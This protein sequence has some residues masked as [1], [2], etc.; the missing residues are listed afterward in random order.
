MSFHP[1]PYAMRAGRTWADNCEELLAH[2]GIVGLLLIFILLMFVI[3]EIPLTIVILGFL[4]LCVACLRTYQLAEGEPSTPP[5]MF[6]P[7]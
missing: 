5:P 4:S 6:P 1:G 2:L 7:A 3:P